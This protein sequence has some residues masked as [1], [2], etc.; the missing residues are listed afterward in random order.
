[1]SGIMTAIAKT[2][3]TTFL[4]EKVVIRVML[5]LAKYL[6]KRSSN[7]LDDNLVKILTDAYNKK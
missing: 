5:E 6:S 2:M 4:T 7:I 1:M 3:L